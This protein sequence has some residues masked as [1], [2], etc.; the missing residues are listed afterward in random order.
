MSD[1][2]F[3]TA[4][5]SIELNRERDDDTRPEDYGENS[6]YDDTA[7]LESWS[8]DDWEFSN[9]DA[10]ILWDGVKIGRDSIGAVEH[11]TM[12]YTD[13]DGNVQTVECNALEIMAPD[14]GT[15]ADGTP[16]VGM[17]SP[18]SGVI[19]EAL[20]EAR[21]WATGAGVSADGPLMQ[22]LDVADKWADPNAHKR[23]DK[24]SA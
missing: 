12:R 13:E 18:A 20:N 22:A 21:K 14:Y 9:V 23:I 11:G 17:G 6:A 2:V 1:M 3:S 24:P 19:M 5:L 8:A 7:T 4:S 15:T 16:T 10:R